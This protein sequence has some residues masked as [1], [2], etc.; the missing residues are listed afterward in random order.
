MT[1]ALLAKA[2]RGELIPQDP[3]DEPA[4]VL[5]E[6]IRAKRAAQP[7]QPKRSPAS[8]KSTMTE[9]SVK[10]VIRQLPKDRFSFDELY[11]NFPS[12]YNLLKDILFNLLNETEPSLTQV[13]DQQERGMRFVWEEK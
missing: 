13:F 8:R 9:E 11:E 3:N 4:S 5:L 6:R 1:P 12:D 7:A 2:F 10:E